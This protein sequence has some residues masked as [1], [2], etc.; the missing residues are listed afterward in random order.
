MPHGAP[1]VPA[2]GS[3]RFGAT[4]DL[5]SV[6]ALDGYVWTGWSPASGFSMPAEN[7]TVTGS[8]N[9]APLPDADREIQVEVPADP[10]DGSAHAT[11]SD[12]TVKTAAQNAQSALAVI[13]QGGVPA[14]MGKADAEKVA[15]L[16]E[17]AQP[18]DKVTVV[19]SLKAVVKEGVAEADRTAIGSVVAAGE[20]IV[21]YLDLSV[22]MTVRVTGADGAT[23]GEET[24]G[25]AEVDEALL[26]EIHVDPALIQGKSVRAA[27][28]HGGGVEVLQPASVDRENGIV[29]VLASRFSTYAL[30]TSDTCTVTFLSLGGSAVASQTVPFG[31]TASKPADPMR[32]GYTFEGWFLD[33]AGT[34]P[35]DFGQALE[36]SCTVYA[37][38]A[39]VSSGPASGP[40]GGDP[41]TTG[42]SH[43]SGLAITGDRAG[44]L[45]ALPCAFVV[46][47]FVV[48][49]A[50]A[51]RR[52]R[53]R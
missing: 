16:V 6:P 11:V 49:A 9:K 33:E 34:R 22:V 36:S 15:R 30:L 32:A 2:D 7:V 48:L 17:Q 25:L 35:F 47:A 1:A 8:W 10:G 14:G 51:L 39:P 50:A 44:A 21:L 28:V 23:K 4:V 18:G 13:E 52:R 5:V 29:C 12:R 53:F 31:G 26:F 20:D 3:F 45:A 27:H 38:W 42:G 41:G 37:Q 24:V 19:V 46:L 43:A 40:E